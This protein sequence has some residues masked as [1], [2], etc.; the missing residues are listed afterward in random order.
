MMDGEEFSCLKAEYAER[1]A[2]AQ[3]KYYRLLNDTKCRYLLP[4][5]YISHHL[6]KIRAV[7]TSMFLQ[8]PVTSSIGNAG[9]IARLAAGKRKDTNG[10]PDSSAAATLK[11]EEIMTT[12][13]YDV[14]DK[15]KKDMAAWIETRRDS[16]IE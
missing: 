3:A 7:Y 14:M 13:A 1:K 16:D 11:I 6:G 4:K 12:L 15:M 9:K 2:A 5:D 8:L 10:I